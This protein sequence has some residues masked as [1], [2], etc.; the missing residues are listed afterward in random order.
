MY[1]IQP[2]AALG[3]YNFS[4]KRREEIV[5]ARAHIGH[6]YITHSYLLKG[7]SMPEC[8]PCYCALTV[9]HILIECVDFMEV[10]QKYLKTL[11][12]DVDPS[13]IFAFLKE[14]VYLKRFNVNH[15]LFH[16]LVMGINCCIYLQLYSSTYLQ[17]YSSF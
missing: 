2:I 14:S 17:L 10:R 3:K 15:I 12:K 13:Q 8:I 4:G 7:D 11:F 1:N 6:S 16:N 9:K 5:L